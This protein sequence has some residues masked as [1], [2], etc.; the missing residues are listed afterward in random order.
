MEALSRN[1]RD[2]KDEKIK[3]MKESFLIFDY[4]SL[5]YLLKEI[6]GEK[7]VFSCINGIRMRLFSIDIEI[8]LYIFFYNSP[9]KLLLW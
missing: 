7:A 8:Y 1:N 3:R 4:N 2:I 9:F 5:I 6:N